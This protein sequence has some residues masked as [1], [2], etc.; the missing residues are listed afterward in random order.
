MSL[1]PIQTDCLMDENFYVAHVHKG[2]ASVELPE[3]PG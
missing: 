2:T 1:F 3:F